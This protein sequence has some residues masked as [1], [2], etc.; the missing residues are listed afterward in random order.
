MKARKVS[1]SLFPF[2]R[3]LGD[4]TALE[5]AKEIGV[6]AVDFGLTNKKRFDVRSAGSVYSGS[7]EK[8]ICYFEG[9][10]KRADELGITI[11]MTHGKLEGFKDIPEE[12]DIL[13]ENIRRDLLA[14]KVLGAPVCVIHGVTTIFM[15]PDC[16]HQKMHDL[17]FTL[18]TRILPYAR[19]YGVKIATETFGNAAKY[20]VCDYFG[21]INEFIKTFHR[22]CAVEDFRKHFTVCMDTGHSNTASRYNHNPSPGDVIRLLGGNISVLHLHDNDTFTDQHK[23][24]MTGSIDWNDVFDALD[25]VGYDGYYNMEL[26]LNWFGEALKKESAAFAVKVMK[27]FLEKRYQEKGESVNE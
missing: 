12:D 13:V 3:S 11:C 21:N 10:K 27:R 14:T 8:L 15:G 22:I 9:I 6:D 7:D 16:P 25:E 26:S 2:Q 5:I 17:N 4:I 18:F 23:I 19:E 20:G 24:P 1:L